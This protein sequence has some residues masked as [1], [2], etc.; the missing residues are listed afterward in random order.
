MN[1]PAK[2]NNW[3]ELELAR[4]GVQI[5][6]CLPDSA[7]LLREGLT[8]GYGLL[9]KRNSQPGEDTLL[10]KWIDWSKA[11]LPKVYR[12]PLLSKT[13]PPKTGDSPSSI[14]VSSQSI[15]NPLR[16]VE[17]EYDS[18]RAERRINRAVRI[19]GTEAFG[20]YQ[21]FHLYDEDNWGIYLRDR[22]L[23]DLAY[24]LRE[25]LDSSGSPRPNDAFELAARLVVEHELF[26]ARLEFFALNQELTVGSAIYR[27]YDSN[28]YRKTVWSKSGALEEALANYV[29]RECIKALVNSWRTPRSWNESGV[30]EAMSYIDEIFDASPPGYRDWRIGSDPLT[31]RKLASQ[32]RF[33]RQKLEGHPAPM[34]AILKTLPGELLKLDQLHVRITTETSLCD[35]LLGTPSLKD[36]IR[37]LKRQG[38]RV[39]EH[40]RGD[41]KRVVTNGQSLQL[42]RAKR[43]N[44]ID[45]ASLKALARHE[46]ISIFDLIRRIKG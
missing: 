35:R 33:G 44:E 39:D 18:T 10:Q 34:E 4:R 8:G 40:A 17:F 19:L 24:A 37:Y 27:P 5:K 12:H 26:H 20:W 13:R 9:V 16:Y 38:L 43:G 21:P 7:F 22:P 3:I 32:V 25:R 45:I 42:N 28:V 29:A 23:L 11:T 41:H 36:V 2:L 46:R 30:I 31:W 6:E 14:E 1:D 15:F